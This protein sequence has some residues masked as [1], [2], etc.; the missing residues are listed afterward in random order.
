MPHDRACAFDRLVSHGNLLPKVAPSLCSLQSNERALLTMLVAR[1]RQIDADVFIGHNFAAFDL[2]VLLHRLQH[3]KASMKSACSASLWCWD[4][5]HISVTLVLLWC[6]VAHC[7]HWLPAVCMH[8]V[9]CRC[10]TGAAW[11][12]SSA[13]ASRTSVAAAISL[14]AAPVPAHCQVCLCGSKRAVSMAVLA[15]H[16]LRPAQ[17]SLSPADPP[18]CCALGCRAL[19]I[20]SAA[21]ANCSGGGP[22]AVRHLPGGA[23]PGA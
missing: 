1:L 21:A 4:G 16:L 19:S 2:D 6:C 8:N 3:H 11:A 18:A 13:A 7:A 22:P 10:R 23:R 15:W 9:R 12:G 20:S 5:D 14:A 17:D